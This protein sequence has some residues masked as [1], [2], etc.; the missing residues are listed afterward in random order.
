VSLHIFRRR[1]IRGE[2]RDARR[3]ASA[4]RSDV[5]IDRVAGQ[6][7]REGDDG[8]DEFAHITVTSPILNLTVR[9]NSASAGMKTAQLWTG[10]FLAI[11]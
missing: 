3:F 8:D 5:I 6:G 9:S 1:A 10:L 2:R 11:D 7:D 4:I